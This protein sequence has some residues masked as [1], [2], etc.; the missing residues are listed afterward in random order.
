M[1]EFPPYDF[2]SK[3]RFRKFR[4]AERFLLPQRTLCPASAEHFP[5]RSAG[6]LMVRTALTLAG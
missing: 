3:Y 5:L 2:Q 1:E 6:S 4:A